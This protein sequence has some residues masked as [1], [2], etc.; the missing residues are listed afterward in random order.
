[1]ASFSLGQI[2]I[3]VFEIVLVMSYA[4]F[5]VKESRMIAN[6]LN[7]IGDTGDGWC[8]VPIVRWYK[9]SLLGD[10]FADRKTELPIVRI[11]IP[12]AVV[13]TVAA[14]AFVVGIVFNS[15]I[16]IVAANVIYYC[17]IYEILT[18]LD[19]FS[20]SYKV[21]LTIVYGL[22]FNPITVM[23]LLKHYIEMANYEM[24]KF[25]VDELEGDDYDGYDEEYG[26]E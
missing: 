20:G 1:M 11:L 10:E 14:V 19:C 23:P 22:F 17:I 25:Q 8:Y 18:M 6:A 4:L 5:Y 24:L 9:L 3:L 7:S 26:E 16:L 2:V 21:A 15:A 12:R 13:T